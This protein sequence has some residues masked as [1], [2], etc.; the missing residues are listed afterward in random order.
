MHLNHATHFTPVTTEPGG[1]LGAMM[2]CRE[3]ATELTEDA[4]TS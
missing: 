4:D 1:V 3:S 2:P